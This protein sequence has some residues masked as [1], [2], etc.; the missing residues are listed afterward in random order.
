MSRNK[1]H[2]HKYYVQFFIITICL[3]PLAIIRLFVHLLSAL[4]RN[5]PDY[6]QQAETCCYNKEVY[7]INSNEHNICFNRFFLTK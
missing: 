4:L 2:Q 3:Y 6:S 1:F 7:I 5:K